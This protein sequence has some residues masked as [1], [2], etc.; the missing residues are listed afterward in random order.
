M[1]RDRDILLNIMSTDRNRIYIHYL[2]KE[3]NIYYSLKI[4]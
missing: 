4:D 3:A 2:N 1:S